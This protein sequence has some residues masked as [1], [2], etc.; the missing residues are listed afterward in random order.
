MRLFTFSGIRFS[1]T[2][3][4]DGQELK[5]FA[6]DVIAAFPGGV[7]DYFGADRVDHFRSY[8]NLL[9]LL[10]QADS[11]VRM[12]GSEVLNHEAEQFA[13]PYG[14]ALNTA[15]A[16]DP[17]E[18]A[19]IL[20]HSQG[21]NNLVFALKFLF[22]RFPEFFAE[23]KIRCA[24][25]DP[26]VG[27]SQVEELIV[28]DRDQSLEFLFFQSENDILGDQSMFVPKFIDEFPH[29]NHI[30]VRDANHS[31]IHEWT[32][33]C[34]P[35]S[36][37]SLLD[38]QKYDRDVDK[39]RIDLRR[40]FGTHTSNVFL[41]RLQAFKDAYPMNRDALAEAL[42]EFLQGNLAQKFLS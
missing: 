30:W 35:Q 31:S 16:G 42:L 9:T 3:V 38:Y 11:A 19:V 27:A 23:R 10:G 13:E 21:C 14:I 1:V 26:K 34:S 6:Q 28:L 33:Y 5:E 7:P 37:L 22:R 40:E 18:T 12:D 41:S 36:W 25:F 2:G 20:A 8:I 24:L 32:T 29:G 15:M 39:E 17:S 4:N